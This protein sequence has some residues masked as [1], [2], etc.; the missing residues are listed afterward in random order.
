MRP[1]VVERD[2]VH[3]ARAP[4]IQVATGIPNALLVGDREL[5]VRKLGVDIIKIHAIRRPALRTALVTARIL[6][7]VAAERE[8]LRLQV[9]VDARGE[10]RIRRT[11]VHDGSSE[12]VTSLSDDCR[13][14]SSSA[15]PP[16]RTSCRCPGAARENQPPSCPLK[17]C[18][19]S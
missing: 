19:L 1:V 5:E 16:R 9:A 17:R 4:T 14:R 12:V 7:L 15:A 3:V 18:R 13:P 8:Q 10:I 11:T 6:A 2:T